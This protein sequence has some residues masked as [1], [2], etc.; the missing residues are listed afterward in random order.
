MRGSLPSLLRRLLLCP[1]GMLL[2]DFRKS[3]TLTPFMCWWKKSIELRSGEKSLYL[4]VLAQGSSLTCRDPGQVIIRSIQYS[5]ML[6]MR[7]ETWP[8][9]GQ[10]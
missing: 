1:E 7:V 8:S 6:V 2:G 10:L 3:Y 9:T 5:M 4:C